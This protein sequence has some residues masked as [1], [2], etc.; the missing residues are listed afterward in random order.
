M[1][2]ATLKG[3]WAGSSV[4]EGTIQELRST[5]YLPANVATRVPNPNQ[6]VPAP[7]QGER[8]VFVPHLVRGLGFPLHPFVRGIMFYY[9][10]DFHHMAPNSILH[11]A[12]FI[13]VCE[14]FLRIEPH[15]GLWLRIFGVKPKSS[16]SDLA[17]CGGAMASKNQK[18]DWFKGTFIETDKEW[19][20]EWFYM[21]EPL[22]ADQAEVPAFSARPPKKLVS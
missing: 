14:A 8:V 1:A 22:T 18:V 16:G 5:G 10:L 7:N 2:D 19:Q 13:T 9:G 6:W 17:E 15:F 11:L 12:S 3:H 21:T 20:R 4:I